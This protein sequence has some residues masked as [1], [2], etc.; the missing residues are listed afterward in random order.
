MIRKI[1]SDAEPG[2]ASAALDVAEKLEIA[3]GGW[4]P[5][6]RKKEKNP[7]PT[8]YKSEEF[9]CANYP[10]YIESNVVNTDGCLLFSR[11]VLP[12]CAET[13]RDMAAQ[14]NKPWLHI[15]LSKSI[16]FQ[17]A[18]QISNWIQENSIEVLNVNGSTTKEDPGIYQA[19]RDI[20]ETTFFMGLVEV[21]MPDPFSVPD[22]KNAVLGNISVPQNL[23]EAVDRLFSDLALRDK[24]HI[25]NFPQENL[26]DLL[27]QY[28]TLIIN[29]YHMATGNIELVESCRTLAEKDEINPMEAALIILSELWD[30]LQTSGALKKIK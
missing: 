17:A 10:E 28:G 20:L 19:T 13:I 5:R 1:I 22:M 16:R 29:D 2:A 4:I 3:Y 15:D 7:C 24:T 30:K 6:G 21:N 8:R 9:Q 11:G 12:V 23:D 26:P 18:R 14:H 25:A 27:P